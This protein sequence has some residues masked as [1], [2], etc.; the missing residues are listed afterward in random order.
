M[1]KRMIVFSGLLLLGSV[2]M[3]AD[4]NEAA[5]DKENTFS[6]SAQIRPRAEYRN[7]VLFP[8]SEGQESA[9]FINNL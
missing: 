6:M 2:W 5:K 3:K 9:G 4:E 7:G 8:R 1:K